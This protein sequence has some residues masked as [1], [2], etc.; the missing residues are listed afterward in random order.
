[1]IKKGGW[2]YNG[3]AVILLSAYFFFLSFPLIHSL[4]HASHED[5][6]HKE[7]TVENENDDCHQFVYHNNQE[8]DCTH[9]GH[10]IE[11]EEHCDLCAILSVSGSHLSFIA[12]N[13]EFEAY[14]DTELS[15]LL[16]HI[17]TFN[18][19]NEDVRGPPHVLI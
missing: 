15:Y 4:S 11:F 14:S 13:T 18:F 8:V 17:S 6:Q 10:F 2:I 9:K 16:E 1:M 19:Y 3:L 5:E 12:I 7:C